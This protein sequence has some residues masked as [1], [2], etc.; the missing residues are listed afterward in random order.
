[1]GLQEAAELLETTLEEEKTTDE[2][3]TALAE[4]SVNWKAASETEGD[5]DE[6][7]EE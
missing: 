7:E 2:N 4:E 5:S 3:L 1:M 6:S